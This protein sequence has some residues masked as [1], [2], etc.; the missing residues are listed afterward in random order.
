MTE[1]NQETRSIAEII[2][3]I[4]I[5]KL[6]LPEFQRD[7]KWPIEKSVA[8]F[9]SLNRNLFIGSLIIAIPKFDLACKGFDL[10]PRGSKKHKP[11]PALIEQ[12][13]FEKRGIYT[14]LDGQ[15]RTTAIYR[16]LLGIDEIYYWFKPFDTL[17][18]NEFYDPKSRKVQKTLEDYIEYVDTK[19]PKEQV[20][21]IKIGDLYSSIDNDEADFLED[22]IEPQL[23]D[24]ALDREEKTVARKFASA[25]LRDFR[26]QIVYKEK[27]LSIQLLDM[28]LEKF[29][30]FFERS[31]SQGMNLSFV[32][33]VNAKVYIDFKLSREI[34]KAKSDF[35]FFDDKLVDPIVRYINFLSNGEVTKDSIL[36]N[37]S[38]SDFKEHWIKCVKDID[39]IQRWLEENNWVF[40]VDKMPYRTMLLPLLSFYQS[41]PNKE[42]TQA[43]QEQMDQLKFWFFASLIDNRFGGGSHGSTNVVI[44]KDCEILS[45]LAQGKRIDK[46]YWSKIRITGDFEGYKRKD[47]A[48]SASIMGLTYFMWY[49]ENF[50]N[51]ENNANVSMS[52]KV[53]VHHV[54]PED[55]IKDKFGEN[56]DEYD[57]AD[58]I[59]NKIRIN[60]ISNIKISNKSPKTYLSEIQN[61]SNPDIVESLKTHAIFCGKELLM[62]TYDDDFFAFLEKRYQ[63]IEKFISKVSNAGDKLSKGEIKGIWK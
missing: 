60:K 57:F 16:A 63:Q 62:G 20:L 32:D 4:G 50:K 28:P 24:F 30:L 2:K 10:R 25:L 41:L 22:Y 11:K 44:K 3:L 52:A 45:E 12:T 23:D 34:S 7:F 29:C 35:K 37:L 5:D 6:T 14:L 40:Q 27:L 58:S 43:T 42:F 51:L 15:Q 49:S 38:G 13:K 55:Y 53:D 1:N 8:L 26:T 31:N 17:T 46:D 21:S 54:F 9:D 47:N 18:S 56:S 19:Q 61:K 48:K 33:I 59:L 36:K 39:Y